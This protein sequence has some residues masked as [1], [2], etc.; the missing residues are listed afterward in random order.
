MKNTDKKKGSSFYKM[1]L[2]VLY[3]SSCS[4]HLTKIDVCW[5]FHRLVPNINW[6]QNKRN[7]ILEIQVPRARDAPVKLTPNSFMFRWGRYEDVNWFYSYYKNIECLI[8]N[9]F[10]LHFFEF[11][12]IC[13]IEL[14][15]KILYTRQCMNYTVK[16]SQVVV[17][18]R[19]IGQRF[20]SSWR[21]RSQGLGH[22]SSKRRQRYVYMYWH[23]VYYMNQ[24]MHF[25]IRMSFN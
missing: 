18:C 20:K 24:C 13:F 19:L 7:V 3:S 22:A 8:Y 25:W 23:S 21:K 1:G 2:K 5:P 15:W 11:I 9:D 12:C 14:L 6:I 4:T 10:F 16:L 17:M